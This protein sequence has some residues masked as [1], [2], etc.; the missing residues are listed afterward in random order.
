MPVP[1][2]AALLL[3]MLA[4]PAEPA[5]A[6]GAAT[7]AV[8]PDVSVRRLSDRVWVHTTSHQL[9]NGRRIPSN[10]LIVGADDH[11]VLVD[12]AWG[13]AETRAVLDW[14]ERTLGRPVT[15]AVLTHGHEDRIAGLQALRERGI[16]LVYAAA[17]TL[18]EQTRPEDVLLKEAGAQIPVA[19]GVVVFYPGA[20]HAP[21]NLMV[22]IEPGDVLFGGCAIRAE[23]ATGLGNTADADLAAW[24][25]AI[26]YVLSRYP[27]PRWV[28]PGHGEPGGADL[29]VLT[30]GHIARAEEAAARNP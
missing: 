13:V 28:V 30:R 8:G 2:L 23:S 25:R 9:A 15:R 19:D 3:F 29:I 27:E 7:T 1:I 18:G 24:R 20:A 4:S 22:W 16:E 17:A 10:G 14:S 5:T 26:H 11:V 6:S 21:D 12:T